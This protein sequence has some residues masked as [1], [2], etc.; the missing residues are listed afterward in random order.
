VK[1][2][3]DAPA[4]PWR[5]EVPA[6]D[7]QGFIFDLDGTLAESMVIHHRAWRV[8][9]EAHGGSFE[10]GWELFN[11]RAGMS[12]EQT[13][14]ELNVQFG[15]SLDPD[16]VAYAQRAE[17]ERMLEGVT[18]IDEVVHFARTH[19]ESS[20]AVAS[21]GD[22]RL[23]ERTL[24]LIGVRELFPVVV[25]AADVPR[26]KPDPDIFLLAASRLGVAP[27][28]CVVFEDGALGIL[29]AERAGM[30]AVLIPGPIARG[31]AIE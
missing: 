2:T 31:A 3:A 15:L 13:V 5:L 20:L 6:G 26:G 18:A 21:G 19:A 8:A 14:V 28:K 23:V 29:A 10:F 1:A 7:F 27:E 9:L 25:V 4:S 16:A 12:H 30:R 24:E 11:S 22:R 17:Y